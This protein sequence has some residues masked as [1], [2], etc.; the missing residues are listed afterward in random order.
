[1]T[2]RDKVDWM[3]SYYPRLVCY[4]SCIIQQG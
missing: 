3:T 1:V 4:A 2:K